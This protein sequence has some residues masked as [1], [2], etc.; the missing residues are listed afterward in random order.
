MR[1]GAAW[2]AVDDQLPTVGGAASA[3]AERAPVLSVGGLGSV[4]KWVGERVD[5]GLVGGWCAGRWG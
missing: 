5:D 4:R 1:D 3:G 2:C